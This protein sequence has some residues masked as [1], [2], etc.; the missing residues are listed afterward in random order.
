MALAAVL[1]GVFN[2]AANFVAQRMPEGQFNIF[3]TA[4]SALG[5]LGIPALGMQAAFAAQAAGADSDERRRELTATMRGAVALL[6]I[7]WLLLA[8]WWLLRQEQIMAA[9][10]LTQPAMLWTLLFILLVTLLTPIPLGTLQGRQDFLVFGWSTLLNGVGRCIVLIIVVRGLGQGAMGGL[11]GVLA[12]AVVVL[13]IAGWRAW[14]LFTGKPG[15]FPWRAGLQ[16]LIPVT[17]GLGALSYI[18][19]MDALVVR[20][21][22]QP[23][24]TADEADGY[25]AVRTIAQALVF[26]IGAL[27]AVMFPKIAR[28]FHRSEKTDVLKLT[29]LLTA[30]I[31][32]LGATAATLFPELPLR[33]LS[34]DRLNAS[35]ALVPAY[36]WALVPVA[37][38]NVIIWSLLARESYRIVPWLAVLAVGYRIALDSFHDR[39]M[40]V[41]SV[42]GAFGLLLLA[43]C[44]IFLWLDARP[45]AAKLKKQ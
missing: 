5:I 1:G 14:P 6:G 3:N 26:V 22:L 36:C 4:L 21:K 25:S 9:Y 29:L 12:G 35:K 10:N 7:V 24:L 18:M 42:V 33:I 40:T 37:L 2:M 45:M 15:P 11:V 41:I 16:R 34:P 8:G 17:I 30:A 38:A 43:V 13:G 39:L 44:A 23:L 31:G 19:Q 27:T 28:S 20:E 32:L